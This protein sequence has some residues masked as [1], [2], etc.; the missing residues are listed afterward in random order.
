MAIKKVADLQG[1]SSVQVMFLGKPVNAVVTGAGRC[2]GSPY[3]GDVLLID[4]DGSDRA[5]D[6]T[7]AM[8]RDPDAPVSQNLPFATTPTEFAQSPFTTDAQGRKVDAQGRLVGDDGRLLVSSPRGAEI[9]AQGRPLPS[10][11]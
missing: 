7:T 5:K 10:G 1:G 2:N 6:T 9:D 3:F 8:W 11:K 4:D